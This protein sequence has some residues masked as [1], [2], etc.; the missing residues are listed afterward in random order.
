LSDHGSAPLLATLPGRLCKWVDIAIAASG[1]IA[2]HDLLAE[3]AFVP[4]D[5]PPMV[6]LLDEPA[7][8]IA[9]LME[10]GLGAMEAAARVAAILSL[11]IDWPLTARSR[12]VFR[13]AGDTAVSLRESLGEFLE[14]PPCATPPPDLPVPRRLPGGL[15]LQLAEVFIAP[16]QAFAAG[17]VQA[18][19]T[20][21]RASFRLG[22]PPHETA[23][24][25][26][27]LVGPARSVVYGP[28]LPLPAGWWEA[29]LRLYFS[30]EA[31]RRTFT[32]DMVAEELAGTIRLKP[33]SAGTFLTRMLIHNPRADWP[34]ALR[35]VLEHGAI[36]GRIALESV[37]LRHSRSLGKAA[38]G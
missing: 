8:A 27:E 16:L 4:V 25:R 21:P 15:A 32:I 33:V 14:L 37:T 1:G 28:Y 20:W 11:A 38:P 26:V 30:E 36:E 13:A 34:L 6:V 7:S 19:L 35:V 2:T 18:V 10:L 3:P 24:E 17:G 31:C 29:E 22:T 5:E 23:P 12:L 9:D